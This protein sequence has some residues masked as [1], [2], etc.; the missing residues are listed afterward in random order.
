MTGRQLPAN[1]YA[2]LKAATRQLVTHAGGAVAASAVTRGGHQNIG[3]YGSAQPDDGERFMPADVIADLE[4]EC[5]QPVLTRA[6]AKL[7]GHLLVPEPSVVKSG[8]ALGAITARALKETSDVFV[9]LA[10][11]WGDGRLCAADAAR[12]EGE[13]EEAIIKLMALRFQVQA[14]V[15]GLE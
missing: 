12:V 8:T 2:A 13:I 7:S 1:D 15:E 4:S 9:A 3:R 5:G 10:E 11:G 14:S 6:L